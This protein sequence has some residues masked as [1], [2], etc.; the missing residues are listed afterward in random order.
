LAL[1]DERMDAGAGAGVVQLPA[2]PDRG[3]EAVRVASSVDARA[4]GGRE[5]TDE[6]ERERELR[7]QQAKAEAAARAEEAKLRRAQA[8][9]R[10]Q[11]AK[12]ASLERTIR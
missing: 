2:R 1:A 12:V 11:M 5:G 10:A 8:A 6:A 4:A 9:V 7:E 3:A